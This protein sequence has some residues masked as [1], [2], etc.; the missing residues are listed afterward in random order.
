[1]LVIAAPGQGAQAPGFLTPWLAE[2]DMREQFAAWSELTGCDLI[3]CGAT[4]G[5]DVIRDTAIAQPLLV[6]AGIAAAGQLFGHIEDAARLC[7]AVAGH[8]VG[9]LVAG[10]MAGVIS[11]EDALRL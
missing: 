9:E 10:V 8:S 7:G 4:A 6:A 1:M 2:P 5:A 3:A 11:A